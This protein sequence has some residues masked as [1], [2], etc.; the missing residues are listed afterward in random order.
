MGELHGWRL[1]P[2]CGAALGGD[3]HSRTCPSCGSAYYANSAPTVNALIEDEHGRV[4]IGRR[5]IEPYR[6]MWDTLGGFLH[7]G[8]DVGEGLRREMRE[9]TGLDVEP[10]SF[11]GAWTDRYGEGDDAV[12]TLNLFWVARADGDPV[13]ADDVSELAWFAADELPPGEEFAFTKVAEVLAA[14]QADRAL[15]FGT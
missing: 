14:W 8:E 11:L 4:L 15:R 5:A 7:E 1:C 13:P 3:D 9:E 6:G 10:V 2:R 12:A